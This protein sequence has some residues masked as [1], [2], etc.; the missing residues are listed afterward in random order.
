METEFQGS[1]FSDGCISQNKNN[2]VLRILAHFL[3]THNYYPEYSI[4]A[5]VRGHTFL[6]ADRMFRRAE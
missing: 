2:I 3:K 4:I 5:A 6:P 1:L